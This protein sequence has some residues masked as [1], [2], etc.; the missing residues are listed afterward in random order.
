MVPVQLIKRK[1]GNFIFFRIKNFSCTNLCIHY[2]AR[3]LLK[4]SS[5]VLRRIALQ[6][7]F[8]SLLFLFFIFFSSYTST[9]NYTYCFPQRTNKA[10]HRTEKCWGVLDTTRSNVACNDTEQRFNN[11]LTMSV[12]HHPLT[13][14]SSW[15][16][17]CERSLRRNASGW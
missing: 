11:M 7:L 13:A 16:F 15:W 9:H 5:K 14:S 3:S 17:R 2:P 8:C 1:K 6:K 12:F 4:A 10:D